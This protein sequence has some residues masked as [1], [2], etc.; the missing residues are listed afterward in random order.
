MQLSDN[1]RLLTLKECEVLTGR[2]VATW[3][4]DIFEKRIP[5]VHIGRRQVRVA[6]STLQK[7]VRDG[8]RPAAETAR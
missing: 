7:M 3:R 1:D 5:V 8:Y 4:R 6:L 2:R